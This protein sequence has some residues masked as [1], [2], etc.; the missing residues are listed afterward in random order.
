MRCSADQASVLDDVWEH[1]HGKCPRKF[2]DHG[3]VFY[4]HKCFWMVRSTGWFGGTSTLN[5]R[6]ARAHR[7]A[8]A[9]HT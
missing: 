2:T 7:Q 1:Q 8:T 6:Q 9:R 4:V 5:P 3:V